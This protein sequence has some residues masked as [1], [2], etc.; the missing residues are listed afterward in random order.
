MIRLSLLMINFY[1]Y[2]RYKKTTVEI[3]NYVV[4]CRSLVKINFFLPD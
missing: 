1:T 3:Q 4:I 2:L